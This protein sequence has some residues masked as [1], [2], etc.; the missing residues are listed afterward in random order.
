MNRYLWL[1]ASLDLIQKR[2]MMKAAYPYHSAAHPGGSCWDGEAMIRDVRGQ[3]DE[4]RRDSCNCPTATSARTDWQMWKCSNTAKYH[5]WEYR[6]QGAGIWM[7]GLF[8]QRLRG[9][10]STLDL[11]VLI[12]SAFVLFPGYPHATRRAKMSLHELGPGMMCPC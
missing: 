10:L 6:A 7:I 3:G 11:W 8:G 9:R 2:S 1:L 12:S 4:R 5:P